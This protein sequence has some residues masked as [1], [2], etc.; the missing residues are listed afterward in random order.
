MTNQTQLTQV[1]DGDQLSEGYFNEIGLFTAELA[2]S[3]AGN[4]TKTNTAS[5]STMTTFTFSNFET[6]YEVLQIYVRGI[7]ASVSLGATGRSWLGL[8]VS[9]GTTTR[10]FQ[11]NLGDDS[12]GTE[13]SARWSDTEEL[14][15]IMSMAGNGAI[16]G[17]SSDF[18]FQLPA[19]MLSGTTYTVEIRWYAPSTGTLTVTN[20][21]TV[22]MLLH[23]RLQSV[24]SVAQS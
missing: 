8:K 15:G 17:T 20:G 13:F 23:K 4:Y 21:F 6:N 10:Y 3:S 19:N 9:D 5:W 11:Q 12:S 24:G 14:T 18:F 1:S 7:D 22:G 16:G 2:D